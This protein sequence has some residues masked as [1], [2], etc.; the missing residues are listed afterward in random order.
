MDASTDRDQSKNPLPRLTFTQEFFADYH[1]AL[2]SRIRTCDECD[3][4]Y[5]GF[6]P[7]PLI[8]LQTENQQ[9]IL[10]YNVDLVSPELLESQPFEPTEYFIFLIKQAAEAAT[11]ALRPQHRPTPWK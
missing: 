8:K 5:T 1:T 4:V 6:L 9:Q 3:G 10:D 11:I 2:V 7:H